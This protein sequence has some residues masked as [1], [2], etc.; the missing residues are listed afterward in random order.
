MGREECLR[1]PMIMFTMGR[2]MD[3]LWVTSMERKRCYKVRYLSYLRRVVVTNFL[4][5]RVVGNFFCSQILSSME[6]EE[7]REK[8]LGGVQS[9]W[10]CN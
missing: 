1:G 4:I 6:R 5:G 8:G 7:G 9:P 10:S 2:R 3:V